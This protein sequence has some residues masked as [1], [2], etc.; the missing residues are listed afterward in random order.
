M[1]II[2]QFRTFALDSAEDFTCDLH[3]GMIFPACDNADRL[4]DPCAGGTGKIIRLIVQFSGDFLDTGAGGSRL[5]KTPETAIMDTPASFAIIF[6]VTAI[7]PT[8]SSSGISL[9]LPHYKI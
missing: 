7:K 5:F 4:Y 8:L 2:P 3:G 9:Y 6:N 1:H